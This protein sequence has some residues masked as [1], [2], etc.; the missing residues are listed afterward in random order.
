[1]DIV[2]VAI[3][4]IMLRFHT[5]L[6]L[7][8]PRTNKQFRT[9]FYLHPHEFSWN[10]S[11]TNNA[12]T[13]Y[14]SLWWMFH[15]TNQTKKWVNRWW[16]TP[17]LKPLCTFSVHETQL[18]CRMKPCLWHVKGEV[19]TQKLRQQEQQTLKVIHATISL[20]FYGT[21]CEPLFVSD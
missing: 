20:T 8:I 5:R 11:I 4:I 10:D 3:E 9:W 6:F 17:F 1:M 21:S 16:T 13:N 14:I 15:S 12:Y 18:W 2:A 7:Q 19:I